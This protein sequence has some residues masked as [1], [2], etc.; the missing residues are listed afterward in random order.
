LNVGD[1]EIRA[2]EFTWHDKGK[3][4]IPTAF[5]EKYEAIGKIIDKENF[6]DFVRSNPD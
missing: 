6:R 5:L 2:F 3:K 1:T 4:K